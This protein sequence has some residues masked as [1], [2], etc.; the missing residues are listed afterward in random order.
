MLPRSTDFAPSP[1]YIKET[2]ADPAGNL[3]IAV[4][5]F[6]FSEPFE[7]QK[8]LMQDIL[9]DPIRTS[10]YHDYLEAILIALSEGV[11]VVGCLAWS[12]V[13]NY[14]VR[15]STCGESEGLGRLGLMPL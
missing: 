12:F 4:S 14:E 15:P 13:D 10:Y 2:W 6:G 7:V 9:Y 1:R 11:N 5:E 8:T 3:P